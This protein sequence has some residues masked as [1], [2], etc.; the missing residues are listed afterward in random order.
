[1]AK[2]WEYIENCPNRMKNVEYGE[3]VESFGICKKQRKNGE[4]VQIWQYIE[5]CPKTMKKVEYGEKGE[6]VESI[7]ISKKQRKNVENVQK[8]GKN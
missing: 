7:G 3:K 8:V 2:I 4:N 1:M 6:K 5:N